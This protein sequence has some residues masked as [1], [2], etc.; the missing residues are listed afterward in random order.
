MRL[1]ATGAEMAVEMFEDIERSIT[2]RMEGRSTIGVPSGLDALDA[3][4]TGWHPGVTIIGARPGTG[5]SALAHKLLVSA[6][7]TQK[8]ALMFQIEMR[9]QRQFLRMIADRSGIDANVIRSGNVN[10]DTMRDL[11]AAAQALSMLPLHIDDDG[12]ITL[13]EIRARTLRMHSE[14]P[15]SIVVID[16]L[17]KVRMS[18]KRFESREREVNE[19]VGGLAALAKEIDTPIVALAALNRECESRPDKR[20]MASDIRESGGVESDADVVVLLY[21]ASKYRALRRPERNGIVEAIVA[22][23]REGEEGTAVVGYIDAITRFVD[24]NDEARDAYL[25]SWEAPEPKS[26]YGRGR[27]YPNEAA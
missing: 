4:T 26:K 20:P 2:R 16:Y 14:S 17:Q 21:R 11:Q 23:N 15:L 24:V 3:V 22:K 5:K 8:P 27:S 9:R 12:A 13:D 7:E 6:A 10:A 25:K 19:I 1:P 18:G